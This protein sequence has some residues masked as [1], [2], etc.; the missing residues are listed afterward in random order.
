M[1]P[2]ETT[3]T[4]TTVEQS[5]TTEPTTTTTTTEAP[6]EQES[7]SSDDSVTSETRA[8]DD[9]IQ[10]VLDEADQKNRNMAE[11]RQT[12]LDNHATEHGTPA[13]QTSSEEVV[14]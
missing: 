6:V 5:T 14:G 1:Q 12:A 7:G 9:N 4:T 11:A 3:T 13:S 10:Q 8:T 2:Y